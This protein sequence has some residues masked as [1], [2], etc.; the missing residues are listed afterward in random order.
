MTISRFWRDLLVGAR[1]GGSP[2]RYIEPQ[3]GD[4]RPDNSAEIEIY[5]KSWCPYCKAAVDLLQSKGI[6]FSV[7]DVTENIA[8]EQEM[9]ERSSRHTVPQIFL[10]GVAVGGYDDLAALDASGELERMLR[11]EEESNA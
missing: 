7:I 9:I 3:T 2:A 11:K 4:G 6:E 8:L 5:S 1:P 10:Y